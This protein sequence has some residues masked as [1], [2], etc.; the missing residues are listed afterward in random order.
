MTI[1]G[2]KAIIKDLE[3]DGYI[4]IRYRGSTY[5][6]PMLI[7]DGYGVDALKLATL[8][9]ATHVHLLKL[10]WQNTKIV[11]QVDGTEQRDLYESKELNDVGAVRKR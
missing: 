1:D 2:L 10:S 6:K 8:I 11:L 4:S 5:G 3:L 7:V 9:H